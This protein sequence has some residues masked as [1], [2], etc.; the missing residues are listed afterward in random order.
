MGCEAGFDKRL[1][2]VAD[3]EDESIAILEKVG[4]CVGN[5]RVPQN[6]RDEFCGTIRFVAG[7][8]AAGDEED[9]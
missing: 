6:G 5:P 1:E 4:N 2:A 9:L 8:E 7:R 3:A